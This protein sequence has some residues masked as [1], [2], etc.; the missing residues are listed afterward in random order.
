MSLAPGHILTDGDHAI[1][2]TLPEIAAVVGEWD[3]AVSL[4]HDERADA[5][6]LVIR[7]MEPALRVRWDR[8]C[9]LPCLGVERGHT[10]DTV[11]V[12]ASDIAEMRTLLA[13]Q[14]TRS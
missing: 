9:K 6:D 7:G 10:G 14:E 1:G 2:V 12:E 11:Y 13:S 3:R 8:Y 5:A 4:T